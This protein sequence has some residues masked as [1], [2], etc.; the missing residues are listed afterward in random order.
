MIFKLI[1]FL[2][3]LA[4]CGNPYG[5]IED[6]LDEKNS[7]KEFG[8][9]PANSLSLWT[10]LSIPSSYLLTT[11][12]GGIDVVYDQNGFI[13]LAAL[14]YVTDTYVGANRAQLIYSHNVNGTFSTTV[15][16]T[17][18]TKFYYSNTYNNIKNFVKITLDSY[19]NPIIGYLEK[20]TRNLIVTKYTNS[21]WIENIVTQKVETFDLTWNYDENHL[22]ILIIDYTP[23]RYKSVR[24]VAYDFISTTSQV[25]NPNLGYSNNLSP[26]NI[27]YNDYGIHLFYK[28]YNYPLGTGQFLYHKYKNGIWTNLN[29]GNGVSPNSNFNVFEDD[30][31]FITCRKD[32][33]GSR[34]KTTLS[35]LNSTTSTEY[36]QY[37]YSKNYENCWITNDSHFGQMHIGL[38]S[39]NY[40]YYYNYKNNE[41]GRSAYFPLNEIF[42]IKTIKNKILLMGR[43]KTTGKISLFIKK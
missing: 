27:I 32:I 14:I 29:L 4:S 5:D 36:L 35:Y 22:S 17:N 8:N 42:N 40:F 19:Q 3:I 28:V 25:I 34:F 18:A 37:K 33:L 23:E 43:N 9:I 41:S 12:L 13:H 7:E 39:Y 20:N 11:D 31:D 1:L 26:A 30:Q 15:L 16:K 10:E 21:T 6:I 2:F 24:Y 38:G